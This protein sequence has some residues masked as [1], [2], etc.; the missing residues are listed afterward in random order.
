MTLSLSNYEIG[1]T[2]STWGSAVLTGLIL[3]ASAPCAALQTTPPVIT[4]D[5]RSY[6]V[7]QNTGTYSQLQNVFTGMYDRYSLNFES[8]I[9]HFYADLLSKQEPLGKDFEKVLYDN[10]WD[11]Y[12][13]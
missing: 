8:T 3:V 7:H 2:P 1:G 5:H 12:V 6:S 4:P 13:S 10:L 11:L 9:A